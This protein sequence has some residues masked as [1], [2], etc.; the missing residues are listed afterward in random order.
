MQELYYMS[1]KKKVKE[2][3]YHFQWEDCLEFIQPLAQLPT[4]NYRQFQFLIQKHKYVEL[5]CI[6]SEVPI[7]STDS[8]VEEVVKVCQYIYSTCSS[9][10]LHMHNS[11]M[12]KMA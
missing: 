12:I 9:V 8:A 1:Y 10:Y 7:A 2:E 6:K 4:F 3:P 5:L 11:L